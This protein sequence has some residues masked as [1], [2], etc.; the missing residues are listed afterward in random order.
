MAK[1]KL[2]KQQ[3]RRIASQQKNKIKD[4]QQ[5]RQLDEAS[6]QTARV[7]SHHGRQLYAETES[8]KRIKCKIRQNLGDIAC[9]DYVL[10]QQIL[11]NKNNE[12]SETLS[13]AESQNVVVAVKERSNLLVKTGFAG[14]IKPVAANIGQL[15]IV[16][17][18]KPKPNPYLI[19]RYLIAAENLPAKALIIINKVDLLNPETEKSVKDLSE[20]YQSIGYHVIASSIKQNTGLEEISDALSNTTSILVGLSGVG[21][22]SIVK[23]ILPKE[24]I[25]IGAT[26]ES[27]GEGKHTTTVSALYHLKCDGII[28]DSPG[29]RDFTPNNNNLNEITNGFVDVRKF[30]GACKFSN[31]SHQNEPG[32]AMK[33]AVTDKKLNKQRFE[34][35]IRLI[36]E[37]NET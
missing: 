29:V 32:C 26:S 34:N 2:S 7:I 37:F 27:T 19:D 18:L 23:A 11:N 5:Q 3:Q 24:E 16:T 14:A 20:L 17:S 30:E 22:S 8:L 25:R 15:V 13:T 31:C 1:R 9:G 36:N 33:Q 12:K 4:N 35:Y 21:K 28:I 6:T 10:V